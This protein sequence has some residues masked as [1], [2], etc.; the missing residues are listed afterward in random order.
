MNETSP[1]TSIAHPN[2]TIRQLQPQGK[3]NGIRSVSESCT[4]NPFDK[5]NGS[6]TLLEAIPGAHS[7]DCIPLFHDKKELQKTTKRF[8]ETRVA[9]DGGWGWVVLIACAYNTFVTAGANSGFSIEFA[10]RI[11]DQPTILILSIVNTITFLWFSSFVITGPITRQFGWRRVGLLFSVMGSLAYIMLAFCSSMIALFVLY[12]LV[13]GI[14]AGII[15]NIGLVILPHYFHKRRGLVLCLNVAVIGLSHAITPQMVRALQVDYGTSGGIL[16]HGGLMLNTIV[17]CAMFH[18]VERH[19]IIL[20]TEVED[21]KTEKCSKIDQFEKVESNLQIVLKSSTYSLP[22]S[23]LKEDDRS[24]DKSDYDTADAE[25]KPFTEIAKEIKTCILSFKSFRVIINALA[26]SVYLAGF[27]NFLI[28]TP[29][30]MFSSGYE[31]QE[32]AW[33]ATCAACFSFLG[34]VLI[35]PLTDRRWFSNKFAYMSGAT[36]AAVCTMVTP[37]VLEDLNLLLVC[38]ATWGLG[39][40]MGMSLWIVLL[41]ETMGIETYTAA[42]GACGIASALVSL[43][44]GPIAGLLRDLSSS[45]VWSVACCAALQLSAALLW[46]LMPCAI[47][48]DEKVRVAETLLLKKNSEEA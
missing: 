17:A 24:P 38:L 47:A 33:V 4:E 35:A 11:V 21:L 18:S 28:L 19:Q 20:K 42:L 25:G 32:V 14:S 9:P 2:K 26:L 36:L 37:F 27:S 13:F 7:E 43:T 29:L 3:R 41:L 12:G 30:M 22:G 1:K 23:S 45:Y 15:Y 34:R 31:T 10:A 40:G 44:T 39:V 16:I 48:K 5:Q 6:N 46:L 8:T